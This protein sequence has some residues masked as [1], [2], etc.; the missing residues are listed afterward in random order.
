MSDRFHADVPI[1]VLDKT[2]ID[3]ATEHLL[4][5]ENL[6]AKTRGGQNLGQQWIRIKSNRS[7][8]L[9]EFIVAICGCGLRDWL[10]CRE[11]ILHGG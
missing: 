10:R 6:I 5:L 11:G 7:Q 9:I 4:S 3:S 8:H 1:L 2:F